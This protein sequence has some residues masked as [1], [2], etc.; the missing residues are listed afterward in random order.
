MSD[1]FREVEE[2][3]RRERL[4]QFWK[5]HGNWLIALAVLVLLGVGGWQLW[6]RHEAEIRDRTSLAFVAAQR[7]NTPH[8]AESAFADLAKTA[9]GGYG[10]L[11]KLSQANAMFSQGQIGPAIALYKEIAQADSGPLGAVARLR[12]AWALADNTSRQAV[13]DLLAPL[14]TP[15][16]AWRPMAREVLAFADYRGSRLKQ[17][18]SEF[19]ALADDG[20]APDGL[21]GRARTMAAFLANGGAADSGVVPPE[22][23]AL[24]PASA[25]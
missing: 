1:I 13:A 2:D 7:I 25:K 19:Q 8:E 20:E 22:A 23:P 4:E 5:R 16:S 6:L 11:A 9:R 18:Q 10:L 14:D 24:K 17:A 21:R 12:A 15:T 3:V